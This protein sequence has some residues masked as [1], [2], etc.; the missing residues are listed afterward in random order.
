MQKI[1]AHAGA[2]ASPRGFYFLISK[3]SPSGVVAGLQ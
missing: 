1:R 3:S 2:G